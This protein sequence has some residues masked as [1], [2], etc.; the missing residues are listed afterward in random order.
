ME[1]D[2]R[3]REWLRESDPS[4]RWQVQRDLDAA[5]DA[6]WQATRARVPREGF[7]AA[8]LAKQ[9]ADGQWAGGAFFPAGYTGDEPGQ[10]W[11]ATTW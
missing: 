7:G 3:V 4:L 10:P 5:D 8:L 1:T 6:V 11:T 2:T 9:D